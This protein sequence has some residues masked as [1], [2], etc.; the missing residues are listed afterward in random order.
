LA[1]TAFQ[2]KAAA[3]TSLGK[4]VLS[5]DTNQL[6]KAGLEVAKGLP[7]IGTGVSLLT[8]LANGLGIKFESKSKANWDRTL[9][10]FYRAGIPPIMARGIYRLTK[11]DDPTGGTVWSVVVDIGEIETEKQKGQTKH[12]YD[13]NPPVVV[14]EYVKADHLAYLDYAKS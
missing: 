11:D 2:T 7:V 1:R 13:T 14:I 10:R 8:S 9:G 4:A 6:L 5:G 3:I 12:G